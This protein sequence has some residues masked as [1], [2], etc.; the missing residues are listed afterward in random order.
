M[1]DKLQSPPVSKMNW[2]VQKSP[3]TNK[4]DARKLAFEL[5]SEVAKMEEPCPHTI[6]MTLDTRKDTESCYIGYLHVGLKKDNRPNENTIVVASAHLAGKTYEDRRQTTSTLM[7][8][9]DENCKK[10]VDKTYRLMW[11]FVKNPTEG[12]RGEGTW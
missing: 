4:A 10:Y 3:K 1:S 5:I 7:Y 9:F 6:V 12:R 2:G 11:P 8:W